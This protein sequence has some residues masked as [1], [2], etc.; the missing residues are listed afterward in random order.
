MKPEGAARRA[1][2]GAG[3]DGGG[4]EEQEKS[5][6]VSHLPTKSKAGRILGLAQGRL[7]NCPL[8]REPNYSTVLEE[9]LVM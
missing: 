4:G 7:R 3:G 5:A 9:N 8:P 6:Q 1:G 2:R